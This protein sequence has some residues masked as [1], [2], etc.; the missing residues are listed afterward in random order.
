MSRMT[1]GEDSDEALMLRYAAGDVRAFEALYSRHEMKLWRF[2]Q[3]S[4]GN[5][6]TAD[7]LMQDVWFAV[8]QAARRYQPTARFTTW[9]FTLA[10]HRVVDR[11]RRSKSHRVHEPMPAAIREDA[12]SSVERLPA[13]DS[14]DPSRQ[15]E[16]M[17]HADA[18]LTALE[19]LP[20][21]QREAFLMQA[22]GALSVAEIAAATGVSFETAKSRLRYARS[23]LQQTLQEYV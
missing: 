5:Q 20:P 4:V 3:R 11:H 23:K 8:V 12:D 2:I 13:E 21:E 7:E 17:Q 6:A 15:A 19:Q 9:L 16:S 10:H 1:E 22:E 18:L 14:A